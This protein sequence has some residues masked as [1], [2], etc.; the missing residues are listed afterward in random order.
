[1]NKCS[2]GID[3]NPHACHTYL[4]LLKHQYRAYE[5][6]NM[7]FAI[8]ETNV[9][10]TEMYALNVS[11]PGAGEGLDVCSIQILN[12]YKQAKF[13]FFRQALSLL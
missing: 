7:D 8:S 9:S 2:L 6:K 3:S 1:M 4:N 5:S 11:V 10:K 13:V 12:G